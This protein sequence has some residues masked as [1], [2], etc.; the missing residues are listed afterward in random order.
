MRGRGRMGDDRFRITQ[1][2]RDRDDL[3]RIQEPERGGLTLL[4]IKRHDG[5]TG[6]HLR[7][8]KVMLRMRRQPGIDHPG[9]PRITLERLGDLL[10][11]GGLRPDAQIEG[12]HALQH[13]PMP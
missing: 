6:P 8:G 1:I 13:A 4:D 5:S 7:H 10:G 2:V 12:L 9:Q 3:Q 11:A